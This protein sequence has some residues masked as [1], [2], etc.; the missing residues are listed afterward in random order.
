MTR[1]T[2]QASP[3]QA[4]SDAHSHRGWA[5][6]ASVGSHLPTRI[7]HSSHTASLSILC[8]LAK[9]FH[10]PLVFLSCLRLAFPVMVLAHE[11]VRGWTHFCSV[12]L[13]S[14]YPACPNHGDRG[15][16]ARKWASP[17]CSLPRD[18]REVYLLLWLRKSIW[19]NT[20]CYQAKHAL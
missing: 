16:A 11:P 9:S 2:S 5:S 17:L 14:V 1:L 15:T 18:M 3:L 19:H 10:S 12:Q 4:W 20:C 6:T 7:L 8:C 13:S